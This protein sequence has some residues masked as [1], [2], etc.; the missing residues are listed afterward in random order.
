MIGGVWRFKSGL[1]S[2]I[3]IS[4]RSI[5]SRFKLRPT[6]TPPGGWWRHKNLTAGVSWRGGGM[7]WTRWGLVSRISW[8]ALSLSE[9]GN[10]RGQDELVSHEDDSW[11]RLV[12][13]GLAGDCHH[14]HLCW[15]G[16]HPGP[17]L[18]TIHPQH[19]IC[20][21]QT[22]AQPHPGPCQWSHWSH[23]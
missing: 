14:C 12:M 13:S 7:I 10:I 4:S 3:T 17:S 21:Y 11:W 22:R 15:T 18:N 16:W 1:K 9:S 23:S 8:D 20:W 6:Q 2:I 5:I 19:I